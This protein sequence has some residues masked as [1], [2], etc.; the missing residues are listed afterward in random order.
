MY[1][2][3][4]I[5]NDLWRRLKNHQPLPESLSQVLPADELATVTSET[6]LHHLVTPHSEAVLHWAL[7]IT[8]EASRRMGA[9][10]VYALIP[11]PFEPPDFPRR[12]DLL[13]KA[14][15]AGFIVIDMRDVFEGH[16]RENLILSSADRHPNAEGHRIIADRL[17]TELLS[18]PEILAT[19]P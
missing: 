16:D 19:E 13:A 3:V 7:T 12:L 1:S 2:S 17:Y 15:E 14:R 10:P 18:H 6:E 11:M 4:A 9:Q 5:E 8:A